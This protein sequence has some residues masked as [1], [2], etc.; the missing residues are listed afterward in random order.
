[1]NKVCNFNW[2]GLKVSVQSNDTLF[3]DLV[4]N[5][6]KGFF[7]QKTENLLKGK[8]EVIFS[9]YSVGFITAL[10]KDMEQFGNTIFLGHNSVLVIHD[11]L[12]TT[13]YIHFQISEKKVQKIEYYFKNHPLFQVINKF[14]SSK[15]QTQLFSILIQEYLE[16]SLLF[17]GAISK[18]IGYLHAAAAEKNGKLLLF[19]GLNGAGKSSLVR[20]LVEKKQWYQFSD[21][22][23]LV[24]DTEAYFYP[25]T[26]RLSKKTFSLLKKEVPKGLLQ[27]GKVALP[28]DEVRFSHLKKAK[29][30]KIFLVSRAQSFLNR[31]ISTH[32]AIEFISQLLLIDGENIESHPL[33]L[34]FNFKYQQ[35]LSKLLTFSL[36][37]V[38]DVADV[39]RVI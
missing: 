28:L 20:Y 22:Y 24:K 9:E 35:N 19:S 21:N 3:L 5:R 38:K 33:S 13:C 15:L 27:F 36:L 14:F 6:F 2:F 11:Y 17:I 12:L 32:K 10:Q 7:Q 31:K 39:E 18:N 37:K 1:M 8:L 29:I 25:D 16:K 30:E 23:I 34:K 4:S 26:P